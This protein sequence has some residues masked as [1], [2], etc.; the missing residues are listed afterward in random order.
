MS[1][2]FTKANFDFDKIKG[3]MSPRKKLKLEGVALGIINLFPEEGYTFT[4]SHRQQEEVYIII[5]GNGVIYIDGELIDVSKGDFIR[6]SHDARRALKAGEEGLQVICAG[7]IP[8]GYPKNP[9]ARYLID[10]G[11]P[12]YDE[13]PPWYE[14]NDVIIKKNSELKKRMKK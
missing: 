6:I 13:I 4:H 12:Y 2:K 8:M 9:D 7:G 5:N 10:D 3:L 1:E 11:I 14:G